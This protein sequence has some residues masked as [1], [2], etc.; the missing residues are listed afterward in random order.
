MSTDTASASAS[1]DTEYRCQ[2]CGEQISPD[3]D[4]LK[5]GWGKCPHCHNRHPQK[6]KMWA[7]SFALL[8]IISMLLAVTIVGLVVA[9]VTFISAWYCYR[10]T[11]SML[12]EEE[13]RVG[14]EVPVEA[15]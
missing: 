15:N 8:M 14:H 5:S 9:P 1:A 7:G 10:K 11:N 4:S 13:Y 6:V 3:L 2:N 12:E